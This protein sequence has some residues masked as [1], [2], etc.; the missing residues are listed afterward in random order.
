[1]RFSLTFVLL[2]I[3]SQR[4]S[5]QNIQ[6]SNEGSTEDLKQLAKNI[7]KYPEFVDGK[8]ILKDSSVYEAKLNY[9]RILGKFLILDRIG[10]TRPLANPD[11]LDKIVAAGDTF[12]YSNKSFLEKM[13]HFRNVNL[14]TKQIIKY[15][16]KPKNGNDNSPAISTDASKQVFIYENPKDDDVTIERYSLFKLITEYFIAGPSRNFY[17]VTKKNFYE[18]FPEHESEIKTFIRDHNVSFNNIAQM[19]KL[20]EYVNNL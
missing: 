8:I 19:E 4:L 20:L 11:T 15:V 18:L 2:I 17:T 7:F 5:A 16:E 6:S 10:Q 13:T 9:N 12:Y 1:M 14:Y 3:F